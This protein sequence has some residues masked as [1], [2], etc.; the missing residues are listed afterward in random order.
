MGVQ[1]WSSVLRNRCFHHMSATTLSPYVRP[2]L[3]HVYLLSDVLMIQA[4]SR[5]VVLEAVI[6]S[7]FPKAN[8]PVICYPR[9]DPQLTV[10]ASMGPLPPS[11]LIA[12]IRIL[13][14]HCNSNPIPS[15]YSRSPFCSAYSYFWLNSLG[16][17]KVTSLSI[18]IFRHKQSHSSSVYFILQNVQ[19]CTLE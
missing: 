12:V 4:A 13:Y 3:L 5:A 7:F 15:H 8:K 18:P 1:L 6:I 16:V 10:T 19:Y 17:S 2:P 9:R 11:D 14:P